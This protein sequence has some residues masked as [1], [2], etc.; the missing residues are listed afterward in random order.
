MAELIREHETTLVFVN[1][2]R[3]A[4]RAAHNLSER[5]GEEHV[6]HW[7]EVDTGVSGREP[8]DDAMMFRGS[9]T[10]GSASP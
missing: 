2:R 9:H 10:E 8:I 6:L 4:E 7:H 5:L 1:T 3:L